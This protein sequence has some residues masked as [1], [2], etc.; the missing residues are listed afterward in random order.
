MRRVTL[1]AL[2]VTT[3]VRMRFLGLLVL[4]V[5]LFA[6]AAMAQ[7]DSLVSNDQ[8]DRVGRIDRPILEKAPNKFVAI[9]RWDT[10]RVTVEVYRKNGDGTGEK[11][12]KMKYIKDKASD[13]L[14]TV[15]VR[16]VAICLGNAQCDT[17]SRK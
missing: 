15:V 17:C 9:N 5:T 13:T 3:E 11:I 6:G 2:A 1:M 7:S 16:N 8:V 14:T 10:V 4:A 12:V